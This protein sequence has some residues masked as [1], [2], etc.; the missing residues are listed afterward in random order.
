MLVVTLLVARDPGGDVEPGGVFSRQDRSATWGTMGSSNI[1]A[2]EDGAVFGE[3]VDMGCLSVFRS[4]VAQI[5]I[6][7][8]IDKEEH[9]IFSRL[10]PKNV[11]IANDKA[12]QHQ[13]EGRPKSVLKD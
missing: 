4:R 6:T 1:S 3:V 9:H 7:Q 11:V 12:D 2:L 10:L 5:A 13:G 8:I